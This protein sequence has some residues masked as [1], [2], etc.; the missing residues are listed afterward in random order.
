MQQRPTM[1]VPEEVNRSREEAFR[2]LC[3]SFEQND[4]KS[5]DYNILGPVGYG[6]RLGEAL[7][8]NTSVSN[9]SLYLPLFFAQ[10][11][12][13]TESAASLICFIR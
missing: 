1:R 7:R 5:T 13:I 11:E 9:L 2:I 10:D 4:P 12:V 8:Y 3:E 6:R